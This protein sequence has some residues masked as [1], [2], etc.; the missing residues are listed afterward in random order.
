MTS[1]CEGEGFKPRL[2]G[3]SES[4]QA[5]SSASRS[6]KEGAGPRSRWRSA[7]R[8]AGTRNRVRRR[9]AIE[10]PAIRTPPQRCI[11]NA[12]ENA[13]RARAFLV[14]DRLG[15]NRCSRKRCKCSWVDS[16]DLPDWLFSGLDNAKPLANLGI[17]HGA[18][19]A[20]GGCTYFDRRQDTNSLLR[21]ARPSISS[22]PGNKNGIDAQ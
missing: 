12:D 17:G 14:G 10:K 22:T 16:D 15:S 6:A 9:L 18:I 3:A 19:D 5:G 7:A 20:G 13:L 1:N 8:S 4:K 2:G 21:S 11:N